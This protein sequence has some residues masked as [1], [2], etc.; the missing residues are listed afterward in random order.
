[1]KYNGDKSIIGIALGN[2]SGTYTL[3]SYNSGII[4]ILNLKY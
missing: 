2:R 4:G 3:K 1:M